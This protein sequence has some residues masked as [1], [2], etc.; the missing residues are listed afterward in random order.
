MQHLGVSI[1]TLCM[2]GI[3]AAVIWQDLGRWQDM[4]IAGIVF[5]YVGVMMNLLLIKHRDDKRRDLEGCEWIIR[6]QEV[7]TP[8]Y[9]GMHMVSVIN[10]QYIV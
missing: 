3:S 4:I 8:I 7:I 5:L 9:E 1:A 2:F 6:V 10:G